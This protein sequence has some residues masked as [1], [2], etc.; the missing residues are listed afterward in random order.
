[1]TEVSVVG[2]VPTQDEWDALVKKY[3]SN[4][5]RLVRIKTIDARVSEDQEVEAAFV[6][7]KPTAQIL[8]EI[9]DRGAKKS[10]E[11][12]N[13]FLIKY[14]VVFGNQDLFDDEEIGGDIYFAL[15]EQI[16]ALSGQKKATTE[17]MIS[18]NPQQ[19]MISTQG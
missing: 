13:K 11:E 14:C 19:S 15:L 18:S 6:I 1:M 4:K 7:R 16:N 3:P 8:L 12:A 17:L 5:L 10:L 9:A 2:A